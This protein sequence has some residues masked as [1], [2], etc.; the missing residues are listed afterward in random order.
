MFHGLSSQAIVWVFAGFVLGNILLLGAVTFFRRK[1][2]VLYL[3]LGAFVVLSLLA[4]SVNLP[5]T[6]V[7]KWLRVYVLILIVLIGFFVYR[8]FRFRPATICL[9]ALVAV[10]ALGAFWSS[11]PLAGLMYK[12]LFALAVLAGVMV[13]CSV[14]DQAE[15]IRDLRWLALISGATALVAAI[16]IA[17]DPQTVLRQDRLAMMGINA[18]LAAIPKTVDI[19]NKT[20]FLA[21]R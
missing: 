18:S 2:N 16:A 20:E 21:T 13:A 14:R 3:L 4:A 9:L 17:I 11:A 7:V 8:L 15:L 12:G 19:N 6:L 5:N 10:Y 1:V